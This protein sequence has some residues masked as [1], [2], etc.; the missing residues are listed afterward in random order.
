LA[1]L[2]VRA[3]ATKSQTRY[4][5]VRFGNV[6]G[7]RGSV[8]PIFEQQI[9]SGG[10]VTITHPSMNRY[11]MT[12]P[13]AS[14]LVIQSLAVGQTGQILILDMGQPVN[15]Y[16]L[17]Q[18]MIYLAGF[19]PEVD[20]PIK[21]TGIRS[22]EKLDESLV[23]AT[24]KVTPTDHPKIMSVS[25]RDLVDRDFT[26]V[27]NLLSEDVVNKLSGEQLWQLAQHCIKI[28]ETD[29]DNQVKM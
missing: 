13:E 16:E 23:A 11:F 21:V 29:L 2:I 4:L 17:A 5:I 7:S 15:I 14:Q 25:S 22:G 3:Y 9:A 1:E 18:Q 20:I 8:V 26:T 19:I 12:A 28:L 27:L 6:L 24:E 10:P